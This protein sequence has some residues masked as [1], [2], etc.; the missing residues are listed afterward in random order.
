MFVC[1]ATLSFLY[2]HVHVASTLHTCI[3]KCIHIYS[4]IHLHC[5]GLLSSHHNSD[6]NLEMTKFILQSYMNLKLH[7]HI[8]FHAQQV[9]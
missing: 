9:H 7:I 5:I 1:V 3:Y 8:A 6:M 4:V 2:I